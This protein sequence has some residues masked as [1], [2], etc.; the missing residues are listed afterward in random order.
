VLDQLVD[1]AAAVA[2]L[3]VQVVLA[4]LVRAL[5][6]DSELNKLLVTQAA[7]AAAEQVALVAVA[8][9]TIMAPMEEEQV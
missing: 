4:L 5:L 7:A 8:V 2:Q 9:A 3:L 1:R 6:V